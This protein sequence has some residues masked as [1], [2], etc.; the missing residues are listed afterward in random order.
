MIR[1]LASVCV[2]CV[3][4][5]AATGVKIT[6][7]QLQELR[8]G[9]T[10]LQQVESRLGPPTT[11]TVAADGTISLMYIYAE[12][13]VRAATFVPI[14]GVFAGGADTRSNMAMLRFGADRKLIDYTTSES[15]YGTGTGVS[16]GKVA[17][18]P[19]P[20]PRQTTP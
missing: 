19:L 11:R 5:C 3:A 4:G 2:L 18:E 9:E 13:R 17:A 7:D 20:Q 15:A 6:A 12:S 14:V 16:A 1:E 10:T 8:K